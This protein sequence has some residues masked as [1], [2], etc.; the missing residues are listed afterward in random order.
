[1]VEEKGPPPGKAVKQESIFSVFTADMVL[2]KGAPPGKNGKT[3]KRFDFYRFC[4]GDG[5]KE[6]GGSISKNGKTIY[7]YRFYR[8]YGRRKRSKRLTKITIFNFYG[9]YREDA[10]GTGRKLED[11]CKQKYLMLQPSGIFL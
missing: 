4:C 5:R 10:S 3:K 2:K 11:L 9:F 7:F 8:G 6:K 1:M